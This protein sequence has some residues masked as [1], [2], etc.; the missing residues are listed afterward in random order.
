[1]LAGYFRISMQIYDLSWK[2]LMSILISVENL[3]P[4]Y[5]VHGYGAPVT[6]NENPEIDI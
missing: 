2:I 5:I 1:M 4:Y 3:L 6:S